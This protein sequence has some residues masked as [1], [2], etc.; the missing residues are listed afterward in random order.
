MMEISNNHT[1][2]AKIL[3]ESGANVNR[4]DANG[5]T[6]LIVAVA[7]NNM[8]VIK[9]L[10]V[11]NADVT[12]TD[13]DGMTAIMMA[14]RSGCLPAAKRMNAHLQTMT[15]KRER[16]FTENMQ[17]IESSKVSATTNVHIE[18]IYVTRRSRQLLLLLV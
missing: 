5:E 10:L 11:H 8:E 1:E 6:P 13:K 4:A 14:C 17:R 12:A 9:L 3:I 2:N 16:E 7:K 15:L 18:N